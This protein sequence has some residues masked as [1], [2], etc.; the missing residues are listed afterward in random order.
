M[1]LALLVL[2][3]NLAKFLR[4]LVLPREMAQWS[5]TTLRERLVKI[6]AKLVRHVRQLVFQMAE[7]AVPKELFAQILQRIWALAPAPG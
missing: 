2:A 6:G 7:V 1:R 3:H 4:C 5:L